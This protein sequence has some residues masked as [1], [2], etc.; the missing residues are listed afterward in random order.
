MKTHHPSLL[1]FLVGVIW[2]SLLASPALWAQR[3]EAFMAKLTIAKS[4]IDR[5]GSL[6]NTFAPVVK[7]ILPAVVSIS[8]ARVAQR[9]VDPAWEEV[10]RHYLGDDYVPPRQAKGLGSGVLVTKDG[11]VP[12]RSR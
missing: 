10:L 4:D 11:R 3:S 8:S 7:R 12:T 9:Q 6:P 5:R 2:L 1:I